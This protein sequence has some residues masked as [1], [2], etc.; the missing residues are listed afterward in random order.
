MMSKQREAPGILRSRKP[1]GA[2][3][4]PSGGWPAQP[5][6][7]RTKEPREAHVRASQAADEELRRLAAPDRQTMHQVQFTRG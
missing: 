4:C 1:C 3:A 2:W 7:Q 5:C 6:L